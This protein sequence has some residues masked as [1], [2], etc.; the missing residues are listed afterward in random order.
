MADCMLVLYL[1]IAFVVGYVIG[2]MTNMRISIGL[3]GGA[4]RALSAPQGTRL[5]VKEGDVVMHRFEFTAGHYGF[6]ANTDGVAYGTIKRVNS[7]STANIRWHMFYAPYHNTYFTRSKRGDYNQQM[8][9][10]G[11]EYHNGIVCPSYKRNVNNMIPIQYIIQ[12]DTDVNW[13]ITLGVESGVESVEEAV[14]LADKSDTGLV[15]YDD[16]VYNAYYRSLPITRSGNQPR[17]QTILCKKAQ[18]TNNMV[19]LYVD[20]YLRLYHIPINSKHQFS[21][22][23][24]RIAAKP[25]VPENPIH[26][27]E[28]QVWS[29]GVN[30]ASQATASQK[31]TPYTGW[32]AHKAIDGDM[33]SANHT[34]IDSWFELT[35]N[36]EIMVDKI[37][38]YNRRDCCY[39]RIKNSELIVYN[40]AGKQVER[41]NMTKLFVDNALVATFTKMKLV[42]AVSG[43][44][45]PHTIKL[46]SL[47]RGDKL[48]FSVTNGG[49]PSGL[50][51]VLT[52]GRWAVPLTVRNVSSPDGQVV[53]FNYPVDVYQA[54]MGISVTKAPSDW[55]NYDLIHTVY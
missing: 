19:N 21:C 35:F 3:G 49:G 52:Q 40:G 31:D 33:N 26:L 30:V 15:V 45:T 8:T 37:V 24:I 39:D 47:S 1:A 13:N 28:I 14:C 16:L 36:Q 48:V 9:E 29:N 51:A 34:N 6:A 17:A 43:A 38:L 23:K 55:I 54:T 18:Y 44:S 53:E 12:K 10:F 46:P 27:A 20:D 41:V 4:S 50:K 22:K 7:D 2:R 25:K 5:T 11:D 42:G 32:E